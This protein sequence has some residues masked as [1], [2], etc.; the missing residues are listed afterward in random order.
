MYASKVIRLIASYLAY[1]LPLLAF[2]GCI[3]SSKAAK[4]PVIREPLSDSKTMSLQPDSNQNLK[5]VEL[6][7]DKNELP[8]AKMISFYTHQY[9]ETDIKAIHSLGEGYSLLYENEDIASE[10]ARTDAY[11]RAVDVSKYP[12]DDMLAGIAGGRKELISSEFPGKYIKAWSDAFLYRINKSYGYCEWVRTLGTRCLQ[13]LYLKF[14]PP[15][16][17]DRKF[18]ISSLNLSSAEYSLGDNL[19]GSFKLSQDGY[20]KILAV[21]ENGTMAQIFPEAEGPGLVRGGETFDFLWEVPWDYDMRGKALIHVIATKDAPLEL[22]DN[23]TDE[24]NNSNE[25]PENFAEEYARSLWNFKRS[26]W[27][28]DIVFFDIK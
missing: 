8:K 1:F 28:S 25:A 13:P 12:L 17:K 6:A 14:M 23:N 24:D 7:F 19:L 15:G 3:S 11:R 5:P 27:T 26:D 20:V 2:S 21:L 10:R 16:K 18:K 22:P 9:E 4:E